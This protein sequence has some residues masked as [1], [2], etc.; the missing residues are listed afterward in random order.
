[1]AKIIRKRKKSMKKRKAFGLKR[2]KRRWVKNQHI[3]S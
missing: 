1:M 2:R 3:K